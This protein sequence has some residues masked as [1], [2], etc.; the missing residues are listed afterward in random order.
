MGIPVFTATAISVTLRGSG[1]LN[2]IFLASSP[3][4]RG[5]DSSWD[6]DARGSLQCYPP[7]QVLTGPPCAHSPGTRFPTKEKPASGS[8]LK[9][10][11]FVLSL[12][13]T[14]LDSSL[15]CVKLSSNNYLSCP[16]LFPSKHFS[17]ALAMMFC[18]SDK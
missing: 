16:K 17:K 5:G 12:T 4:K 7:G 10:T 11:P 15:M 2:P 9:A 13:K 8:T 1:K 3:G 18:Y 6:G 14:F